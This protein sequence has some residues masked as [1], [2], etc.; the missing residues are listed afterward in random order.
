MSYQPDMSPGGNSH[1][2]GAPY[3]IQSKIQFTNIFIPDN[4]FQL[5][6]ITIHLIIWLY[7]TFINN[8]MLPY[9]SLYQPDVICQA[10]MFS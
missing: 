7:Y 4:L 8:Y 1:E 6:F 9:T 10:R 3:N 2:L 5:S